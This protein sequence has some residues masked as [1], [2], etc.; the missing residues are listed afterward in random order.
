MNTL[1]ITHI[2]NSNPVTKKLFSGVYPIDHLD[3]IED[4]PGFII[5]NT[6]TSEGEGKHW[7]AIFFSNDDK[8]ADFFDSLG[9][10]PDEYGKY[11]IEF[12]RKFADYCKYPTNRIQ[13]KDSNLCGH[14]CIFFLHKRCQGYDMKYIV[15]NFPDPDVIKLFSEKYLKTYKRG[16]GESNNVSCQC[17]IR[18]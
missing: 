1:E 8:N 17:C 14:Y 5:C 13:P 9:K 3:R 4:K 2:L 18:Q 7:I 6:D 15:N 10:N 16:G 11:Y 12:I